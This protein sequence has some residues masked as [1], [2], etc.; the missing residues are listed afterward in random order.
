[1]LYSILI[2]L[3]I[4]AGLLLLSAL[5]F[6]LWCRRLPKDHDVERSALVH[7]PRDA[8][9]E[10]IRDYDR[11]PEWRDGV[12][13][14]QREGTDDQDRPIWWETH[15]SG[16]RIALATADEQRPERLE[17]AIVADAAFE[18]RW[19]FE[20]EEVDDNTTRVTM[21]ESGTIESPI[22]RFAARSILGL[23]K[24]VEGYLVDLV[25]AEGGELDFD[26]PDDALASGHHHDHQPTGEPAERPAT[27]SSTG[28]GD[29]TSN[30]AND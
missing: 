23:E 28:S 17:R 3:A 10:R 18:G 5:G 2:T 27:A 4:V 7:A 25:D 15:A 1:M 11:Q 13:E 24:F 8:V 12:D 30:I 22:L 9:W 16:E 26:P 21:T 29:T 6:Y 14:V 20:L 19:L